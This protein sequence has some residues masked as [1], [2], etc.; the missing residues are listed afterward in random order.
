MIH[1]NLATA[2]RDGHRSGPDGT[3]PLPSVAELA[4]F[5]GCSPRREHRSLLSLLDQGHLVEVGDV[6]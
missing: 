4:A 6:L 3:A 5:V 1:G 2:H